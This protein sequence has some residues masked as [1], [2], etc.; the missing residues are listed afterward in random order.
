MAEKIIRWGVMGAGRIAQRFAESLRHDP[1]CR[2]VAAS[3]RTPEKVAKFA[4]KFGIDP[5][6]AY[7]Q[8]P[9]RQ[10][11]AAGVAASRTQ[12]ASGEQMDA[13]RSDATADGAPGASVAT[14]AG[15]T[16]AAAFSAAR[17]SPNPHEELVADPAVDAVYLALPHGLHCAWAVRALRAG[18][19]V[20]CEKP[21]GLTAR[22][23]RAMT[24]EARRSGALF[25][26]GMKA[27]F[28][29]LYAEVKRLLAEGAIGELRRVETSLCN[30]VPPAALE[31]TYLL[32][33]A[34]GGVLLDCGI[35]CASWLDDLLPGPFAVTDR[36]VETYHG[37]DAYDCA[38]LA[39]AEGGRTAR[40]ECSFN[41]AKPRQAVLVGEKGRITVDDLHRAQRLTLEVTG[42]PPRVIERPYVV[43][44]FFGEVTHFNDLLEQGACESPVMPLAASIRCAEILDAVR[45]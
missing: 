32:D 25:M 4:E 2:L 16:T 15:S 33:G 30:D 27:R 42:R 12:A 13:S 18:K 23:A 45:G 41:R 35:Y 24:A 21:A 28:V 8:E 5:A 14:A 20:L 44:D 1:R 10:G 29:P 38:E 11:S 19:A 7:A 17:L 37:V 43:D 39:F 31:G 34:Q 22:E 3:G 36:Q 26:E 40:L 6:H 9:A